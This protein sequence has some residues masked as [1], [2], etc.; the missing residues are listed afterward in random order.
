MRVTRSILA[1]LLLG[2]AFLFAADDAPADEAFERFRHGTLDI[3]T[4][5][6]V[7][8]QLADAERRP[9]IRA[10][11][12][13]SETSPRAEMVALLDHPALAVRLGALELLE[14]LAGGDLSY[15][16]WTPAESPENTAA[17][18]RPG[19]LGSAFLR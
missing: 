17:L 7:L 2:R 9:L 10:K 4:L 6:E 12:I 13:E 16:P 15:N 5:A 1:L 18:A 11:I 19:P 14:E 3:R 8:P